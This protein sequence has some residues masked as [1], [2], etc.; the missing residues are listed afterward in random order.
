MFIIKMRLG[1]NMRL[2]SIHVVAALLGLTVVAGACTPTI[3]VEAPDKPIH[4]KLDVNIKQEVLLRVEKDLE[5]A[6][7][8]P[9][10]PMAKRAGWIGERPDGYLG[11]VRED[12]PT[13]ITSLVEM[14]NTTRVG[15]YDQIAE[16]HNTSRET[17]EAVAGRK[18]IKQS[19]SGEFI[20]TPESEWVRK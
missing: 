17:V 3:K 14:A 12:A 6:S 18:L 13:E 1:I 19:A 11:L 9:A 16:K 7:I 20:M 2:N 15:R 10:I 5:G 8:T 4:V